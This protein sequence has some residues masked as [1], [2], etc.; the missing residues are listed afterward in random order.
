MDDKT[1]IKELSKANKAVFNSFL[2]T[3]SIV[4]LKTISYVLNKPEDKECIQ[5]CFDDV[6]MKIIDKC[7]YFNFDCSFKV[8]IITI[9]RNTSLD[10]KRKIQKIYTQTEIDEKLHSDFNLEENLINKETSQQINNIINKLDKSDRELFIKKYILDLST[11]E[12]C[13]LYYIN[14]N[15]LYKKLS[16]L[17]IKFKK[18]WAI[19]NI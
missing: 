11:K 18:L 2:D 8:W 6:I 19:E 3:Y 10:Y 15:N 16:R 1:F 14:E 7:I 5:E 17:R 13:E 12:L 9:A 4:L